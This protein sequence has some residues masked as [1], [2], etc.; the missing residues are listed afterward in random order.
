MA[1]VGTLEEER[2]NMFEREKDEEHDRQKGLINAL[3]DTLS[4]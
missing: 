1:V 2:I 3:D 4:F